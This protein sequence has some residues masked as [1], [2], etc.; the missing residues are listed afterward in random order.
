VKVRDVNKLHDERGFFA[1]A[2]RE[3]WEDI[4]GGDRIVQLNLSFSYPGVVRAWHRH[5][6]G[7][8]DY[9]M[10]LR[11]AMKICIYDDDASSPTR[12]QLDEI[13][14]SSE[15]LQIVRFNGRYWHGTKTISN[16]PSLTL[17][18]VNRLYDYKNPDEE[19]R[20]WNDRGFVDAKTKAP[21]D[22]NKSPNK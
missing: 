14:A 21:F 15:R 11:G 8:I 12:G 18:A 9:I 20:P 6:R 19:K 4:V 10:V 22:W 2:Y 5:Q 3:D 13:I 17:Y 7:Q 16:D 1:E